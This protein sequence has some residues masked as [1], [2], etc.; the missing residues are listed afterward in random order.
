MRLVNVSSGRLASRG[1][2]ANITILANDDP[3]GVFE[4]EPSLLVVNEVDR[5]VSLHIVR[6]QGSIGKAR[7][8]YMSLPINTSVSEAVY[9]RGEDNLDFRPISGYVDFQPNQTSGSFMVTIMDDLI[10]E[11]NETIF[12]NLTSVTLLS[13]QGSPG[14]WNSF[15]ALPSH[16]YV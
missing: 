6:R 3:Y 1:V 13:S 8:S 14:I 5:N 4:F 7:V 9:D 12:V 10:P 16:L 11:D 2:I 15:V